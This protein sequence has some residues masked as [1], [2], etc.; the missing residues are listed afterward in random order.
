M[1]DAKIERELN[2]RLI[3]VGSESGAVQIGEPVSVE[4][5]LEAGDALVIYVDM[6]NDVRRLGA[7]GVDTLGL[8]QKSEAGDAEFM[9]FELLLCRNFAL[10]PNKATLRGEALAQI[11]AGEV[12][13]HRDQQLARFVR[14][15][16]PAWRGKQRRRH[17]VGRQHLAVTIQNVGTRGG[18][19][20]GVDGAP[21]D[22]A[23]GRHR[24]EHEPRADDQID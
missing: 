17:D 4:P 20:V 18:D 19:S 23:F 6:T 9:H 22:V 24:I 11:G 16:D 7:L 13:H 1:L 12:G 15:D 14:I 8:V 2:R 5:F 10:E 21:R 3:A